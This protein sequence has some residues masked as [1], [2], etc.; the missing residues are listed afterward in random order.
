MIATE[1]E[2]DKVLDH[3][4]IGG[5]VYTAVD[6][7]GGHRE[8]WVHPVDDPRGRFVPYTTMDEIRLAK[9]IETIGE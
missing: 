5:E 7:G 4:E 9:V 8:L 3:T 6:H 2:G 1:F